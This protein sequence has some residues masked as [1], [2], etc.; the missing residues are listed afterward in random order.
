MRHDTESLKMWAVDLLKSMI[1][2]P[3]VS[4]NESGTADLL[5]DRLLDK[6]FEVNRIKNNVWIKSGSFDPNRPTLM[7]NSHHDTVKPSQSYTFDPYTPIIADGRLY[8]L[9]SNDAGGSVV[10][11][12]AAFIAVKECELPVNLVLALT[13][14]EEV[15]GEHGMRC[16]LGEFDRLGL[17]VDMTLV[18]EPTSMQPAIAERGLIVLDCQ[19]KGKAGHA[20]RDNGINAIYEAMTDIEMLR[21]YKFDKV[22]PVLGDIKIS[23]TQINAGSQHNIIPDRCD[24][25][26]DVRTTDAYSNEEVAEMLCGSLRSEARPRSTRVRASVIDDGHPLVKAALAVSPDKVSFVS[27]T[28]SDMALLYDIPSLKMGPG[29]SKR[30]HTADE[31]IF[32]NQ[33]YQAIDQYIALIKNII[34]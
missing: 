26:I 10:S 16:L 14:E 28:T 18:G 32:V 3:S 9:G 12:A 15:S 33:I 17:K 21:N 1:A 25:V 7:L 27:P 19:A 6:G 30:S 22:S 4:R 2:V 5:Y 11:L 24:F 29:D 23:V 20:A 13:A 34:I 31:F 8:G